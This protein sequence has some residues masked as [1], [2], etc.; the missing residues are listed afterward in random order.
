MAGFDWAGCFQSGCICHSPL[1]FHQT[2]I[3]QLFKVGDLIIKLRCMFWNKVW[4]YCSLTR[5]SEQQGKLSSCFLCCSHSAIF[6]NGGC[7]ILTLQ[8]TG[9]PTLLQTI[10]ESAPYLRPWETRGFAHD[11]SC[12]CALGESVVASAHHTQSYRAQL[13]CAEEPQEFCDFL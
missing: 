3:Q 1:C 9:K 10:A 2:G 13:G 5:V 8:V 4:N 6:T 11:M 7:W 12:F